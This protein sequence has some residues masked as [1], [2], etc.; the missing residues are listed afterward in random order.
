[1]E[2]AWVGERKSGRRRKGIRITKL[3]SWRGRQKLMDKENIVR[4]YG[5][6]YRQLERKRKRKDRGVGI[7]SYN[8]WLPACDEI[9]RLVG[10]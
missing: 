5:K 10:L 8:T 6:E 2:R 7:I 9:D 1:M 4:I 3:V